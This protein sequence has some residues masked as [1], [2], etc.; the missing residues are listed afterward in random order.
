MALARRRPVSRACGG[1]PSP[2]LHEQEPGRLRDLPG[3]HPGQVRQQAPPG[4]TEPGHDPVS[5][6]GVVTLTEML[7]GILAAE[8]G[9]AGSEI[10][11]SVLRLAVMRTMPARQ[12]RT[13]SAGGPSRRKPAQ[14]VQLPGP[15][16]CA[17]SGPGATWS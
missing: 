16:G 15:G 10:G 11:A 13:R 6:F 1:C 4:S 9:Q 7:T 3:D 12:R 2:G 17:V 5:R 14:R 8:L